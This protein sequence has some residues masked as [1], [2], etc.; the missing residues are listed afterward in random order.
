MGMLR[1]NAL[2]SEK[3]RRTQRLAI[4]LFIVPLVLSQF[5]SINLFTFF[6]Q[7]VSLEKMAAL[8]LYPIAVILLG[9]RNIKITKEI[10]IFGI[11]YTTTLLVFSLWNRDP[12][13]TMLS[14]AIFLCIH[15]FVIVMLVSITSIDTKS[16]TILFKLWVVL[17]VFTATICI[18]Q[19]FGVVSNISA[20]NS[21]PGLVRAAG[22]LEDPNYQA[23]VLLFGFSFL[24]AE[25]PSIKNTVFLI[26]VF[27][28]ILSTLSRMGL[29]GVMVL[30]F[31]M[32]FV[33]LF[34]SERG[35][36]LK[37]LK[38]RLSQ[39]LILCVMFLV[40]V[41]YVYPYNVGF[42]QRIQDT[43]VQNVMDGP[44]ITGK[45]KDDEGISVVEGMTSTETRLLLIQQS[46][47]G[48]KDNMLI[49]IGFN[50]TVSYMEETINY[51]KEI[52][53]T[54]LEYVLT[55]GI[56]GFLLLM[57]SAFYVVH[58]LCLLV[59]NDWK[60]MLFRNVFSFSVAAIVVF[61]FIS[62]NK[63]IIPPMLIGVNFAISAHVQA[64][65]SKDLWKNKS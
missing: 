7:V 20:E 14:T 16:L 43:T 17:S 27:W 64:D 2:F 57:F 44:E 35:Y 23:M 25:S 50:K 58:N 60:Q 53:N 52:H 46:L 41:N 29:L 8:I 47:K 55:G 22:L 42:K 33:T 9:I 48:I 21:N 32:F 49:G 51:P 28:G 34:K 12:I 37:S 11:L 13:T 65:S 18:F 62:L 54:Y 3:T 6:G 63:S 5:L 31:V 59:K 30:V 61:M 15:L 26:V 39:V 45:A 4:V 19:V 10:V 1:N 56:S 36:K 40:L 24:F 38:Y